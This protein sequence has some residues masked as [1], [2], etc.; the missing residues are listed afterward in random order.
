M[1]ALRLCQQQAPGPQYS[2]DRARRDRDEQCRGEEQEDGLQV[3]HR[4][5][6]LVS[7]LSANCSKLRVAAAVWLV[8]SHLQRRRAAA[9]RF[10]S[11]LRACRK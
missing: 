3:E 4:S 10:W 7:G 6:T 5:A 2:R 9:G 1:R 8:A 11:I